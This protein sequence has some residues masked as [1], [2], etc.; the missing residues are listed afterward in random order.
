MHT[1]E[2]GVESTIAAVVVVIIAAAAVTMIGGNEDDSD[3]EYE[4]GNSIPVSFAFNNEIRLAIFGNANGDDYLDQ[5]DVD[6]LKDILDGKV[7]YDSK[8][9][10]FADTNANGKL[11]AEDVKLLQALVN[12]ESGNK[13]YYYDAASNIASI[14]YPL[15]G[16]IATYHVY[17]LD[18]CIILGLYDDVV[19]MS[20]QGFQNS[21]GRDP[22]RYPGIGTKIVN[23]GTPHE[24]CQALLASNANVYLLPWSY[25]NSTIQKIID[26]SHLDLQ[27]VQLPMSKNG[28][29]IVDQYGALMMLG[30]MTQTEDKAY[31]YMEFVDKIQDNINSAVSKISGR[32]TFLTP[33]ITSSKTEVSLDSPYTS[34]S[35]PGDVY[36]IAKLPMDSVNL[37]VDSGCPAVSIEWVIDTNPNVIVV[38][39]FDDYKSSVD[40]IKKKFN[41]SLDA[42]KNTEAYKNGMIFGVNYYNI[43]NYAGIPTLPLLASYIWPDLFDEESSMQVLQQYYE[44][45]TAYENPVVSQM[46]NAIAYKMETPSA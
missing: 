4:T 23:I 40:D 36:T 25:D 14:N 45:Y 21:I 41:D 3:K 35:M 28:P 46:G 15:H 22:S 30:V 44:K 9:H 43:A 26:S 16:N 34:G 6:L 24:D 8:K 39:M 33:M 5:K 20:N 29:D 27:I 7:A 18:A 42:Y 11:D 17:P 12:K 10:C 1:F 19:G 13:M 37:V 38:I 31:E 2:E 32:Y